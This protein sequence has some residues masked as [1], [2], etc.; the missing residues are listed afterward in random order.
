MKT[1][2]TVIGLFLT[3][4]LQCSA[5][6]VNKSFTWIKGS[7]FINVAGSYGVKGVSAT[8]NNPGTRSGAVT[9]VDLAGNFWLFGGFGRDAYNQAGVLNDLW[10]YIPATNQWAWVSGTNTVSSNGNYGVSG[11]LSSSN[12]PGARMEGSGWTDANGNLWL[13]GGEGIGATGSAMGY[14]DDLWMYSMAANQWVW[15]GGSNQ[16]HTYSSSPGNY[17][18][19]GVSSPTNR[20]GARSEMAAWTDGSGDLW[21]FGGRTQ[22]NL[23]T[24][25]FGDMWRYSVSSGEW[26]W[27]NG[28][29]VLNAVG[30]Y[31]VKGVPAPGNCPGGRSSAAAQ[32]APGILWLFG[33]GGI[34][35]SG[36][37]GCLND[38]WEFD[39]AA[40]S[41]TWMGGTKF[42]S[43]SSVG[44]P[45]TTSAAN[46]P[47]GR[48]GMVSWTGAP[49]EVY[50]FGGENCNAGFNN[51]LWLYN[52]SN[53]KWTWVRTGQFV[54]QGV[55]GTQSVPNANNYPGARVDA[56]GWSDG[57][58]GLWLFGGSSFD[59]VSAYGE[60]NDLWRIAT[61]AAQ[62]LQLSS[63]STVLCTGQTATLL[64]SGAQSFRWSTGQTGNSIV[65][66]PG[67]SATFTVTSADAQSCGNQETITVQVNDCTGL[68]NA[69]YLQHNLVVYPN[70]CTGT[71][72][73]KLPDVEDPITIEI[74][75]GDGRLVYTTVLSAAVSTVSPNL[76]KGMYWIKLVNKSSPFSGAVLVVD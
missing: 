65:V 74:F 3:A 17:G 41:W 6:T 12:Q 55:Y 34:D 64:A 22:L 27:V 53:G 24:R 35:S 69:A 18:T 7:K 57:T 44:T 39:V 49:N 51:E 25:Y 76:T 32:V 75:G 70:P 20:P 47:G 9:W 19:L 67:I 54:Q 63:T 14:L 46:S 72:S 21:L 16:M 31:G 40:G 13:F 58:G 43:Q 45:G 66:S 73:V 4:A 60:Q 23:S 52:R 11:V 61:C 1:I 30:V 15:M 26:T 2:T 28:S 8:S 62:S 59:A 71:F 38:M 5:Q 29:Q 42:A 56:M 50:I 33:G 37:A 10:K 36:A 68:Q 48:Q